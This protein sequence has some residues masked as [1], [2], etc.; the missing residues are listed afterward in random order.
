MRLEKQT[1]GIP[2]I[3]NCCPLLSLPSPAVVFVA[4]AFGTTKLY[5][6]LTDAC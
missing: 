1:H 2:V 3:T 5:L 4:S 6:G